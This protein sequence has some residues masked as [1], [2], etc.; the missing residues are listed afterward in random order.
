MEPQD[1]AEH[2][3]AV[4]SLE[5][6]VSC[7]EEL[8]EER[9]RL[10]RGRV[11]VVVVGAFK[12]GK[13]T[14]LN[15]LMG[16]PILPMGVVPVT[17]LVTLIRSGPTER[18]VV[19]YLDGRQEEVPVD[20]LK[21]YVSETENPE[22]R[23]GVERVE[24]ELPELR[25]LGRITLAD[26]PGSGSVFQHN[27]DTL[28]Q[29]LGQIDAALFVVSTDPPIG[30]TDSQL[31]QEVAETAGEVLVVLNKADHLRPKELG[32]SIAYTSKAV[33]A[34]MGRPVTLIPCSARRALEDGIK[35]EGVARIAAWIRELAAGRGE[36]VLERAVARRA[37]RRL[38]QEITLVRLEEASA[39]SSV[40]DLE[41]ALHQLQEVRVEL[42]RRV[43]EVEAAF[44]AGCADLMRH[45]DDVVRERQPALIAEVQEVV[46]RE[47]RHLME[48]RINMLRFQRTLEK[49]RDR[50]VEA[51]LEPFQK[52]REEAV[53]QGFV[54]LT[55]RALSRVNELVDEAFERAARLVGVEM[56]SF[57][58]R[59]SFSMESRLD[60][61]VGLP[62]VNLDY[63]IEGLFLL[64]PGP[65]G[66]PMVARRHNR[67]IPEA[68]GRQLGLIRA[69]LH[70][71]LNESAFSFKGGLERRVEEALD[72]LENAV[73]RGAELAD[74]D[75]ESLAERLTALDR[76]R[77]VLER[78]LRGCSALIDLGGAAGT[79]QASY[80]G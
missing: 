56:A 15:A 24:V 20:G 18:A 55:E 65:V 40:E 43:R 1:L 58:V 44:Q 36:E 19:H 52:E 49:V 50:T 23:L 4:L 26:T 57:D 22:N 79:V 14:L 60:Y 31:L 33:E 10:R 8:A 76:R 67:F 6:G 53:I 11:N 39:R 9:R 38:A 12:R 70:E 51:V 54:E 64:L 27:T 61:R 63:I 3:E 75:R 37:A 66:R 42:V 71:R 16:R 45:H 41:A 47:A 21:P 17:A 74:L 34:T 30:E 68:M 28:R 78:A 7:R 32:D 48:R 13:S 73:K 46:A 25:E 59:E 69:D 72:R 2:L 77:G 35:D 29:W 62:K 5:P 80:S